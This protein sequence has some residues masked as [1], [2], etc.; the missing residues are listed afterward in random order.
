MLKKHFLGA[1]VIA[2]LSSFAA[3]QSSSNFY[4]GVSGGASKA[5]KAPDFLGPAG[6]TTEEI[7]AVVDEINANPDINAS[8]SVSN[9]KSGSA[10]KVYLGYNLDKMFAF[11]IGYTNL[12]KFNQR[13]IVSVDFNEAPDTAILDASIG[14][15]AKNT[16]YFFDVVGSSAV[17]DKLSV[18]GR[19]GAAYIKTE[20]TLSG[21]YS[22]EYNIGGNTDSGSDSGS[23]SASKSKWVPKIGVGFDYQLTKTVSARVDYERYFKVGKAS[24]VAFESDID[25]LTAGLKFSF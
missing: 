7:N 23:I 20:S 1:I 8:A 24:D 4:L 18:L 9:D 2:S 19:V 11:E 15:E 22:Y 6:V 21:A 14:L 12:G 16:G 17:T 13:G 3:A 5:N 25:L 10:Y